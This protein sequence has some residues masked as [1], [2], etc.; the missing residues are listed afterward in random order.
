MTRTNHLATVEG[1][2]AGYGIFDQRRLLYIERIWPSKEIAE[3]DVNKSGC[4]SSESQ[5][6]NDPQGHNFNPNPKVLTGALCLSS[7]VSLHRDRNGTKTVRFFTHETFFFHR[8]TLH[9]CLVLL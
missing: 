3:R 7:P 5:R 2:V 4:F 8:N 1:A 9:C 6:T